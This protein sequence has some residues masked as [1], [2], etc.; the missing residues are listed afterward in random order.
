MENVSNVDKLESI[1][2]LQSTINNQQ[3]IN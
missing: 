1:K 3:S 2:S